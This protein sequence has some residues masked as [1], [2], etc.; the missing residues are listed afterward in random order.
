MS[1]IG[2]L[3]DKHHEMELSPSVRLIRSTWFARHLW[4]ILLLGVCAA[5]AAG[6]AAFH[7]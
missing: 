3:V 5:T 2:G 1:L 4:T 7:F 6:W